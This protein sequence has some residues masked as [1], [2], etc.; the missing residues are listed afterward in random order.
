MAHGVWPPCRRRLFS[1]DEARELTG[2][3]EQ[4]AHLLSRMIDRGI[5][6]PLTSSLGRIFDAAAALVLNRRKVEY[7]AQAAI[8]L[9][10]IANAE[11][12]PT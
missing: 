8:E 2:A 7:D 9:E 10:G 3:N 1:E 11:R 6:S 4:E 12:R 5:N